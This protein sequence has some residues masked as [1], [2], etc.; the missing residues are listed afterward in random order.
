MNRS[1]TMF[2]LLAGILG[3]SCKGSEKPPAQP[4][5]RVAQ[6][7]ASASAAAASAPPMAIG[8]RCARGFPRDERA[9]CGAVESSV[10]RRSKR[11]ESPG[12]YA[13]CARNSA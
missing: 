1:L 7:S 10:M 13:M 3:L 8:T 5:A 12:E 9:R 6:P 11:F 4:V 2:A